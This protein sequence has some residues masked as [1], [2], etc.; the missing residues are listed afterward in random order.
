VPADE[1]ASGS[2]WHQMTDTLEH[3]ILEDL[4]QTCTFTWELLQVVDQASG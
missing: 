2:N 3:V 1:A 4:E